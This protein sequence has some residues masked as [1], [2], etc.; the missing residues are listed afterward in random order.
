MVSS[1]SIFLAA[2]MILPASAFKVTVTEHELE[3]PFAK[4]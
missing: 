2:V 4:V 3:Q 1:Q